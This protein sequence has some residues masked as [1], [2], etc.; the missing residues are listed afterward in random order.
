M[1]A[2]PGRARGDGRLVVGVTAVGVALLT[3]VA[4]G[5]GA[6]TPLPHPPDHATQRSLLTFGATV[7]AVGA[8][9]LLALVVFTY[10]PTP[11]PTE[12]TEVSDGSEPVQRH[13]QPPP[14]HWWQ[15]VASV[16]VVV[17][18]AGA[19][20]ALLFLVVPRPRPG[21][22][23]LPKGH[24]PGGGSAQIAARPAPTNWRAI[25][26]GGATVL[27]A[28]GLALRHARRRRPTGQP[29]VDD[30]VPTR[31]AEALEAVDASLDA[32]RAEADCRRAVIA[33]YARM[34]QWL[35]QAGRGRVPSEAPV[36][37]LDR[38]LVDAGAPATDVTQLTDLFQRARFSAHP[39]GPDAKQ[40]AV[41]ALVGLRTALVSTP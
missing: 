28:A 27:L 24:A 31:A 7:F 26:A 14:W 25:G 18:L 12:R 9:A 10:W 19:L 13:H 36:E 1:T 30:L 35:A 11:D 39:I 8:A 23:P 4:A 3:I 20:L 2:A 41:T 17:L 38:I 15:D 40:A 6:T 32:L 5:V 16:I 37:F 29:I 22:V 21:I 34:E 33:A